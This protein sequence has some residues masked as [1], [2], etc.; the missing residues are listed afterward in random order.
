MTAPA[1]PSRAHVAAMFDGIAHRYDVANRVLSLGLDV[2]WRQRLLAR[3]PESGRGGRR[4]RVLDV[5]TGTADVALAVAR[6]PRV[7]RVVGVDVSVGMLAHGATKVHAAGFDD[8]ITLCAGDARDLADHTDNDV[9]TI[10]FGIRNVPDTAQALASMGRALAPGGTLLILEFAEP[11]MPVFAPAYRFYRR[12]LLPVVGGTIAGDRA[13]YRYLDDT[14]AT[15]PSGADFVRLLTE[16]GFDD[17]AFESLTMGS[18]H[19][20]RACWPGTAHA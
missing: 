18:V 2:G 15:F 1:G 3:L 19:L 6:D 14:I 16:A 17:A 5:A 11:T 8:R 12:H 9:V 4:L 13:A 7:D 10:S 20:Y